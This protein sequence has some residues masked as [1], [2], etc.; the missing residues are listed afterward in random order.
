M[1]HQV[2]DIATPG[3]TA[4]LYT[5]LLDASPELSPD[6][7]PLVLICPG[8][9]YCYTSDREAEPVALRLCGLGLH[10]CILRYSVAPAA[11]FPTALQQLA[12]SVALVRQNAEA[13]QVNPARIY[14]MGFSAGGHLAAS[15]GVLWNRPFAGEALGLDKAQT[16][17]DGLILC[18]PVITSGAASHG[19]SFESLLGEKAGDAALLEQVSLEKQVGAHT[20]PAFM[21]HTQDDEAVPVENSLLFAAALRQNNVPFEMHIYAHG[22]HGLSLAD[23][24]SSRPDGAQ[25]CPAVQGWL[26]LA[27]D[28]VR[29]L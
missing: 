18:Y 17:P 13:W 1:L 15:L 27:A 25:V 24:V 11:V 26:Q 6:P 28:W 12:A 22:P 20:P 8:G 2:L 10:C 23:D 29:A 9:G 19:G 5:Y 7:R 21:W 14:V 16:K 4:K 3:G